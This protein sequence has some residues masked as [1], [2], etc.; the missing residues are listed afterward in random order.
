MIK[1]LR[2]L[3][4]FFRRLSFSN[5]NPKILTFGHVN[6]KSIVLGSLNK[7]NRSVQLLH[8]YN[9]FKINITEKLSEKII[10]SCYTSLLFQFFLWQINLLLKN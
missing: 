10:T 2:F 9:L 3:S 6:R 1:Y 8:S 4:D 7:G 5:I